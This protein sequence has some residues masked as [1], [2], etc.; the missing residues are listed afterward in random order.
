MEAVVVSDTNI[1][2]DLIS[3]GL[4]DEFFH[5]P[6][7]IHT[8]DFIIHELKKDTAP[9][10]IR[11]YIAS[12]QLHVKEYKGAEL[13][14]LAIM[15]NRISDECN[16]TIQDCSVWLYAYE[17]GY[18]LLTGDAKLR[19]VAEKSDVDVHGILYIFDKLVEYGVIDYVIAKGKIDMLS[20]INNRLPMK[21]IQ[22]RISAWESKITERR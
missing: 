4:L 10:V 18:S 16:A 13:M 12:N 21:E 17:N 1:F 11:N 20:E 6:F 8:T 7:E 2:I 19:R 22:K 9:S 3:V 5:L 15:K 14:K